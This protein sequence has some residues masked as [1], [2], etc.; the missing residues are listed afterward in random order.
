MSDVLGAV[1][2]FCLTY[3]DPPKPP[4]VRGWQNR[5]ALPASSSCIVLTLLSAARRGTNARR[6]FSAQDDDLSAEE[7][8]AM[9]TEYAVQADFCGLSE[10][11][12]SARAAKIALLWEDARAAEFLRPFGF[13]PYFAGQIRAMPFR[14]EFAQWSVRYSLDLH[15]GGWTELS[16]TAEAFS[17]VSVTIENADVHHVPHKE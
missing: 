13:A 1:H 15:L 3:L 6:F 2:D 10:E 9:L 12:E 7:Q 4:I 14:N 17:G 11:T 16:R 5:A 8:K